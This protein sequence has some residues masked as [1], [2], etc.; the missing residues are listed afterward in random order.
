MEIMGWAQATMLK[1]Y[2]HVLDELRVDAVDKVADALLA[3]EQE[4]TPPPEGDNVVGL[5]A[6]RQAR[7]L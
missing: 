2:Q 6:W 3:P 5:D 1:R 7:G 4:S